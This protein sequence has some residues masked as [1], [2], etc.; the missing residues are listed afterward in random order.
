[1]QCL[2]DEMKNVNIASSS[3]R[4]SRNNAEIVGLVMYE[5]NI[6]GVYPCKDYTT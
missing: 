2:A 6:S 3:R 4:R 1:M 5:Y